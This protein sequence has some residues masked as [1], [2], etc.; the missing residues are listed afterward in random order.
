MS[1]SGLSLPLRSMV[2]GAFGGSRNW[3]ALSPT[4]LAP[5]KPIFSTSSELRLM[6]SPSESAISCPRSFAR[7]PMALRKNGRDGMRPLPNSF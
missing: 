1:T 2:L 7:V 5:N 3:I 4:S 6:S